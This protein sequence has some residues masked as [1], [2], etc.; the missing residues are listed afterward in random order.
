MRAVLG[1]VQGRRGSGAAVWEKGDRGCQAPEAKS[2]R[3]PRVARPSARS[4]RTPGSTS[5]P[6]FAISNLTRAVGHL[7]G[8]GVRDAV[9]YAA[10][11]VGCAVTFTGGGITCRRRHPTADPTLYRQ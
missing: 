2:P 11:A 4:P 9:A 10:I 7:L 1:D 3:A 8:A 5:R 6:Y